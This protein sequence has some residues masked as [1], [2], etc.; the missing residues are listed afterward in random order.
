MDEVRRNMDLRRKMIDTH[1]RQTAREHGPVTWFDVSMIMEEMR[2]DVRVIIDEFISDP[3]K[4]S[5]AIKMLQSQIRPG[6]GPHLA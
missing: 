5:A 4:R 2:R 3:V 6:P 1:V